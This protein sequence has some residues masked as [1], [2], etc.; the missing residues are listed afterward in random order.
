MH[1]EAGQVVVQHLFW[2]SLAPAAPTSIPTPPAAPASL[3][4]TG[5]TEGTAALLAA[6]GLLLLGAGVGLRRARR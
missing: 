2:S 4:V 6:L 1:I 3:P 5:G